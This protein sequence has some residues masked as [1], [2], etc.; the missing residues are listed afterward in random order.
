MFRNAQRVSI[1]RSNGWVVSA[2]VVKSEYRNHTW[3]LEVIRD[4]NK[5]YDVWA[6][7]EYQIGISVH[8]S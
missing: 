5:Q 1:E 3:I 6:F 4:D 8:P 2:I 7:N